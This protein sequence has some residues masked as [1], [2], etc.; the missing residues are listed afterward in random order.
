VVLSERSNPLPGLAPVLGFKV[1]QNKV[2]GHSSIAS[3]MSAKKKGDQIR[4]SFAKYS[5]EGGREE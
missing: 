1:K 3:G 2:L 4:R 5:Y